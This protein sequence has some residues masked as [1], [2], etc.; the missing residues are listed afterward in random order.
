MLV[1]LR[2]ALHARLHRI[3]R[4][5]GSGRRLI[6]LRGLTL[7]EEGFV[8]QSQGRGHCVL[9]SHR[10]ASTAVGEKARVEGA[11]PGLALIRE[12]VPETVLR[13]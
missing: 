11:H 5:T 12:L 8:M 2:E 13:G 10:G 7:D 3:P 9:S 4:L 6:D 1:P